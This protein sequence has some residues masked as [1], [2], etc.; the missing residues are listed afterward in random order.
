MSEAQSS[1][2]SRDRR[3]YADHQRDLDE[4][5]KQRDRRPDRRIRSLLRGVI[6]YGDGAFSCSCCVRDFTEAGA[7]VELVRGAVIPGIVFLILV[8]QQVAHQATV[9]WYDKGE[10][11]LKFIRS[12]PLD[13][14]LDDELGYLKKLWHGSALRV[15]G[16]D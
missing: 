2:L 10:V 13:D 9:M 15:G 11:G 1:E 7:R 6:T 16:F 8:N 5:A 3:D 4:L 12:L 14:T